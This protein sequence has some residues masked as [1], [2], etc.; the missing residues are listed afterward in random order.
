[1]EEEDYVD[2]RKDTTK[3]FH[4][5]YPSMTAAGVGFFDS[6]KTDPQ[7]FKGN[8][9]IHNQFEQTASMIAG[10]NKEVVLAV[11]DLI[12]FY[13]IPLFYRSSILS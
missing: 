10:P 7:K 6:S 1:M 12:V 2:Q 4:Y 13:P 3:R 11:R 5:C 8:G 9:Y